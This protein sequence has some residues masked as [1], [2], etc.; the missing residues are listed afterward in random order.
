MYSMYLLITS[1]S[2]L[3]S[4]SPDLATFRSLV[5]LFSRVSKSLSCSSVSITSL[6]FTGPISPS[7]CIM[8]SSSKHLV[9]WTIASTSLMFAKNWFP[10]PSPLLAPLTKPAISTNSKIAGTTFSGS[11]IFSSSVNRLSGTVTIPTSVSYTHLTLPTT[12]RV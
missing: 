10:K 6:S 7:T 2:F 12:S 3:A 4:A 11:T 8:F 5:F 9:T 1:N